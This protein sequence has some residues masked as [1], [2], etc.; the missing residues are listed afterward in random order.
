MPL[1]CKMNEIE[2]NSFNISKEEWI[3]LK[4]NSKNV[5]FTTVCCNQKCIPKT[6]KLGTQFFAHKSHSECTSAPETKEHLLAKEII[7]KVAQKNGWGV[8]TEFE[9]QSQLGDKWIADVYCEKDNKKIVFEVQWSAQTAVETKRRQNIYKQSGIRTCW[10]MKTSKKKYYNFDEIEDTLEVPQFGIGFDEIEKKFIITKFEI[11]LEDM[12]D[13]MLQGKLKWSP[14]R[15]DVLKAKVV[16]GSTLCWKCKKEINEILG[17][18]LEDKDK[19][20]LGFLDFDYKRIAELIKNNL[21]VKLCD[22]N[23]IGEIKKSY[24]NTIKDYYIANRCYY[25]NSILGNFYLHEAKK[26]DTPIKEFDVIYDQRLIDC[27]LFPKWYFIG[28]KN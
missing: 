4:K 15:G 23:R 26:N 1:R 3:A 9:G 6:S 13:G 25:C 12:V 2:I 7:A 18:E 8:K 20:K 22:A 11:S 28:K 5:K 10:F 14:K 17:L 16:F 21:E 19:N 27:E 24:S